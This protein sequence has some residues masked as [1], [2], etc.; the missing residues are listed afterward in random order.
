MLQ[1]YYG[2]GHDVQ[3]NEQAPLHCPNCLAEA[4]LV[5]PSLSVAVCAK[6]PQRHRTSETPLTEI[7]QKQQ[8]LVAAHDEERQHRVSA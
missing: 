5:P 8:Y 7:V 3:T 6:L 2:D 4:C 1:L